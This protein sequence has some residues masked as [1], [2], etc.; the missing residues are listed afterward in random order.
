VVTVASVSVKRGKV[1]VKITLSVC[2]FLTEHHAL[3]AYCGVEVQLHA[4]LTSAQ[5]RG[6]WSAIR[7]D[8]FTSGERAPGACWIGGWVGPRAGL[9]TVVRK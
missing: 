6:E 1:K 9:D 3:K 5:D 7:P 8:R 4:F 2:F